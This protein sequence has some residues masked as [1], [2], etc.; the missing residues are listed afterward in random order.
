MAG[1]QVAALK[2]YKEKFPGLFE[3]LRTRK[4]EKKDSGEILIPSLGVLFYSFPGF[5]FGERKKVLKQ[6]QSFLSVKEKCFFFS[7]HVRAAG[8][9]TEAHLSK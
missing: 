4:E 2:D 1:T 8:L 9:G 7:T 5:L 6:T 3:A